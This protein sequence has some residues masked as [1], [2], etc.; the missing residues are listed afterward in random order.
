[1]RPCGRQTKPVP[2]L[3][4]ALGPLAVPRPRFTR[5]HG[6]AR[7][8]G[9]RDCGVT[10]SMRR[11]RRQ[12]ARI[13]RRGGAAVSRSG[14]N[15]VLGVGLAAALLCL[16]WSRGALPEWLA[17]PRPPTFISV[18]GRL[19]AVPVPAKNAV[20]VLPGVVVATGGSYAF[21]DVTASGAPVGFDPCRP[22]RYVVRPDGAPAAG[23][24]LI[25]EAVATISAATGLA[26]VDAGYTSEEPVL[27][28]PLV[29]ARYGDGWAPVL[30][31]WSDERAY[32]EL[33]GPTAGLG[34]ASVVPAAAGPGEFLAGGRVLLDA[35]DLTTILASPDGYARARAVVVHEVAHVVGL[36]HVA[37]PGELMAPTMGA[38]TE[39]GPGDRTGLALVGQVSC[40]GA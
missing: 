18:E 24:R 36:D 19:V 16:A 17:V 15:P 2:S 30:F 39:L 1:M 21:L 5:T 3:G 33:A 29:Q 10:L 20:R 6:A 27:D 35:P 11:Y 28:R 31:G 26:F 8:A 4:Q 34:G 13:E 38:L 22:I 25:A 14:L 9:L 12:A 37:D 7:A 32:P 40:D 23:D